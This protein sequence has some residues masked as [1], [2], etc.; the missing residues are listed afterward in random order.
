MLSS[1]VY[2]VESTSADGD[3]PTFVSFTYLNLSAKS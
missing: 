2:E 1:E 3:D